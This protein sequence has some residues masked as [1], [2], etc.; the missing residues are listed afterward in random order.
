MYLYENLLYDK[1]ETLYFFILKFT[2]VVLTTLQTK[3]RCTTIL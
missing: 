1:Q 3:I 2:P